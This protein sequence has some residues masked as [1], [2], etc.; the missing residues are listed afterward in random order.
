MTQEPESSTR[1]QNGPVMECQ[2]LE[3]GPGLRAA[4]QRQQLN[5]STGGSD[6]RL[7]TQR[8]GRGATAAQP[9]DGSSKPLPQTQGVGCGA[10][11]ALVSIDGKVLQCTGPRKQGTVA[12]PAPE[13]RALPSDSCSLG[14]TPGSAISWFS[15][16]SWGAIPLP[17]LGTPSRCA[18]ALVRGMG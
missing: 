14:R 17:A 2:S 11:T 3:S 12:T 15:W 1:P 9:G 4:E 6:L 13:G 10:A 16:P 8:G 5:A 7:R 18:A